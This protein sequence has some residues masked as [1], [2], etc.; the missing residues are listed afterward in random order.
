[1]RNRASRTAEYMA[2]FRAIESVRPARSRLFC[3]PF[4]TL[5]LHRWRKWILQD[6]AVRPQDAGWWSCSSIESCQAPERQASRAQSGSTMRSHGLWKHPRASFCWEPVSIPAHIVSRRT[7][8][9]TFELDYAPRRRSPNKRR[10]GG[11]FGSLPKQVRF[12]SIDFNAQ[13]I[14]DVLSG[15]GFD[16]TQSTCFVWEG[17]TNYLSPEAVDGALRQIAQAASGS[18]LLFTYVDRRVL[19][20]PKLFFGAEKL[21]SRLDAIGEPWTFGLYPEEIERYLAAR[22]LRLVRDVSVAEVWQRAGRP[23][24]N[25]RGY[26]FYRLASACVPAYTE[27]IP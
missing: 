2:L 22:K 23:G 14:V 3:D 17:V 4:A 7:T 11:N 12:I 1:M 18:I 27:S 13:S 8:R 19:D 5:F 6:C 10:C 9:K 20:Q 25:V 24:S 21:L 16:A 26:E 15:A